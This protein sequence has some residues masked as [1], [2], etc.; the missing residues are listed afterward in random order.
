[1]KLAQQFDSFFTKEY[2]S[3]VYSEHVILS[4][5][6]GVDNMTHELLWKILD[7]QLNIINRKV[8]TSTYT[9]SKYKLKL[10]SK[11]RGKSPR[12]ISI[13]TIRDKITLRALCDF[14]K[15]KYEDVLDFQLPQSIVRQVKDD[16]L[17]TEYT[18][19]IKLDVANFYPSIK[20]DKLI[21]RLRARLRDDRIIT[22]VTNAIK[23]PTLSK[24]SKHDMLSER[25]VPQGLSISNILAAIFLSNLDKRIKNREDIKYYRY[26]DDVLILCKN[27]E[28]TQISQS[29]VKNF[30]KLGLKVY[31]P[32]KY[33]EKSSSGSLL[34]DNFSYLG[35]YFSNEV[36]SA[37]IGS[38]E[39][40]RESL[41]AIFTGY[42]HS[43]LKSLEFLEWRI[44]L[45]VTGCI[46]QSK[47]KGWMYFF[48]EINDEILLHQLD[49]FLK[50]LCKRFNTPINLKSFVRSYYQIQNNRRET[51]YIPNFDNY[52]IEE[53]SHVLSYFFKKN[54]EK[55]T[56]KEIEYHFKKRIS[57]QV[58]DL[59]TD[60]KDAGY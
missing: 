28:V 50:S 43:R 46:F 54:T 37:R 18:A 19:F 21:S 51:K 48:S 40:L 1:M 20:H 39:R 52:T 33:P 30:R 45:R 13:P 41:L 49:N 47:S 14:L 26:V 9:F 36:V 56:A 6:T 16:L 24:P 11:G 5:A 57:R 55:L 2:L 3:K 35:Y 31:D 22:L 59:E 34:K 25:G 10:I 12:E 42:K 27:E 17:S 23:A 29:L 44:N 7:E 60:V 8:M 38:V 58:K 15:F 4:S 32:I 53:K